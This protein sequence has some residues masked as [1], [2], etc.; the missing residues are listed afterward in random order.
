MHTRAAICIYGKRHGVFELRSV[1]F[2]FL[3][4]RRALQRGDRAAYWLAAGADA[5]P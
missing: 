5:A 4:S 3:R 2:L 1:A